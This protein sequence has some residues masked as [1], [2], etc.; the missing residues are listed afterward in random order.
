MS[1]R[2]DRRGI[3]ACSGEFVDR[4]CERAYRKTQ[5]RVEVRQFRLIWLVALCFFLL[6]APVDYWWYG[7]PAAW[8]LLGLR[9]IV[10]LVGALALLSTTT[11]RGRR[12]RDSISAACLLV[13]SVCYALLQ[14]QRATSE[15]SVGALLLLVIGIYLFSPGKFWLVVITAVFCSAATPLLALQADMPA[16]LWLDYSYLLPANLLAALVLS[17]MNAIRRRLYR[18]GLQLRSEVRARAAAQGQLA[19]LH[20]RSIAVLHNTLPAEIAAQLSRDPAYRPARHYEQVTVLFADLVGFSALASRLSPQ[21]LLR[22]LNGLFSRFD[23]L[24]EEFR[25]EKIKTVGDAYLAVAGLG[26]EEANQQAQAAHM[27]LAQHASCEQLAHQCGLPLRLRIGIHS[28]PVVA[29]V[30]GRQRFAFDVWGETVNVASRLESAAAPGRILVSRR[31]RQQCPPDLLFGPAR[32]LRLRGCGTVYASTLY[33]R[34][35]LN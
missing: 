28:G 15:P 16:Q 20:E 6:Y 8:S 31:A 26:G 9:M 13:V 33:S 29:G 27:A 7:S 2:Q 10:L 1:I 19:A 32:P 30:I 23:E 18:Q 5:L 34:V 25:L 11:Q 4:D 22:L 17:Q 14:S 3:S 12:Y 24:A 35:S 21:E